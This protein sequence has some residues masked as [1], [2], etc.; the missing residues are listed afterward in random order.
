[1]LLWHRLAPRRGSWL[2]LLVLLPALCASQG[3]GAEVA[4]GAGP[5][6]GA[7]QITTGGA[8]RFQGWGTSLAWWGNVVGGWESAGQVEDAIF[9]R[10]NRAHADRLGLNVIR[11]NLGA[12]P[13][14]WCPPAGPAT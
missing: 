14:V 12:S 3:I 10:S 1:M 8:Y 9:G 2:L 7:V 4:A 5:I 6:P 13:V 11:Y